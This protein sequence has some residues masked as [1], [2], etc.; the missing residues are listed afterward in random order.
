MAV[1]R[2][3]AILALEDGTWFEGTSFGAPGKAFGEVVFNTSMTGYQEI[4]TD[5]SYRG[6][7][8]AMTYPHIGNTG[9]NEVDVESRQPWV[10]GLIVREHCSHPSNYRMTIPLADYLAENGIVAITGVD[11]RALTSHLRRHGSKKAVLSTRDL[12]PKRLVREAQDSPGLVG[13]DL[14]REVTCDRPYPW[15][16]PPY[17]LSHP[18]R[19]NQMRLPLSENESR[20]PVAAL[21]CGIKYNILRELTAARFDVTV[22]PAS[23]PAETILASGARGFF[24]MS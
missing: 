16:E 24:L 4:L 14:V 18:E 23:T 6:Q 22:F 12:D 2:K 7:M 10:A 13:R 15:A 11:T 3:K 5:P 17:D 9:V 1:K 8:V 20:L 21:D 19:R